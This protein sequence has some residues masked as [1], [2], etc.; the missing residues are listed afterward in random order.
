MADDDDRP[1]EGSSPAGPGAS[2]ALWADVVVPDDIRELA[3]D[4]AAYH[5]EVRRRARRRRARE[6]LA[7]RGAVPAVAL[8]LAVLLAALVAGMLTVMTPQTVTRPPAA[9]RLAAPAVAPGRVG[10]LLPKETLVGPDGPVDARAM[11]PTVLALVPMACG[12]RDLLNSLSGQAWGEGMQ[13]G[14]VV[15]SASDPGIAAE[16]AALRVQAPVYY[17]STAA[18]ATSVGSQGLTVVVVDRDGTIYRIQRGVDPQ[19]V[20]AVEP[21]LQ[22]M[23]LPDRP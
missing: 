5:R 22:S 2:D 17:D 14:I 12:C 1:R 23:L 6:L 18:I 19:T 4:V 16:A 7:R 15:P 3:R 8:T 11:R 13:L 9:A 21:A 10:G 20:T